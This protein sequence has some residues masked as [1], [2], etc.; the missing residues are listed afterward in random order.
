[1]VDVVFIIEEIRIARRRVELNLGVRLAGNAPGFADGRRVGMVLAVDR[2]PV[3]RVVADTDD[4][5]G[6][7]H[8]LER[9]GQ[10]F[11]EPRLGSDRTGRICGRM[12]VVKHQVELVGHAGECLEVPVFVVDRRGHGQLETARVEI[13]VGLLDESQIVAKCAWRQGF[14]IEDNP[15]RLLLGHHIGQL[16]NKLGAGIA[17]G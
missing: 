8:R 9:I 4:G 13:G 7:G 10:A 17:V 5:L 12:L 2:V 1:M 11:V 14:K 15:L 16:P 3:V 6:Q